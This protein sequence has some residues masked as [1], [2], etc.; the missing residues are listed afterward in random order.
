MK[1]DL[2]ERVARAIMENRTDHPRCLVTNWRGESADNL[3]VA[4]ALR[5]AR[6]VLAIARPA[7][8]EEAAEWHEK[9]ARYCREVSRDEPRINLDARQKARIAASHHDAS[10]VGLRHL[11]HT[12]GQEGGR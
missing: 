7:I 1:D 11:A 10:A 3:H 12:T 5:Q 4:Q 2:V 8:L 6:A 9:N